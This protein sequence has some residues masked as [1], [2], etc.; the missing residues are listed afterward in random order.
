MQHNAMNFLTRFWSLKLM[1]A[2]IMQHI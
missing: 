2:K 1:K